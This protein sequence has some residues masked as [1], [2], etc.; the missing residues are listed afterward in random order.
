[1][2]AEFF[3]ETLEGKYFEMSELKFINYS[4]LSGKDRANHPLN[5]GVNHCCTSY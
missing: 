2:L 5:R 4:F 1:M 3:N